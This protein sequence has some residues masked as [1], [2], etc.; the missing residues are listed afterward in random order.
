METGK[1]SMPFSVPGAV[2]HSPISK[3]PVAHF[4]V[5]IFRVSA[6]PVDIVDI[7]EDSVGKMLC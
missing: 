7:P 1:S 6:C 2:D 4:P 3:F 5:S